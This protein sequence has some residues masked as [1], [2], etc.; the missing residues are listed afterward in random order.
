M[1]ALRRRLTNRSACLTLS[2]DSSGVATDEHPT[3]SGSR[4]DVLLQEGTP[5]GS[6]RGSDP[7]DAG[8]HLVGRKPRYEVASPRLLS[9]GDSFSSHPGAEGLSLLIDLQSCACIPRNFT[10]VHLAIL[11]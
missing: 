5:L 2:I 4:D 10:T 8:G 11:L 9:Q 6:W 7:D 1:H 3:A